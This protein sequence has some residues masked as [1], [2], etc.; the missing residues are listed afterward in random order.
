MPVDYELNPGLDNRV[1]DI[2]R[3]EEFQ[4]FEQHDI[5]VKTCLKVTMDETDEIVPC[6]GDKVELKKVHP[7]FRLFAEANFVLVVDA[8]TWANSSQTYM[9]GLI[10]SALMRV[11]FKV[12]DSGKV[13]VSKRPFDVLEFRRT[14]TRY[15]LWNEGVT[16]FAEMVTAAANVA[17]EHIAQIVRS[18]LTPQPEDEES[19]TRPVRRPGRPVRARSSSGTEE[20]QVSSGEET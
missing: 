8:A 17:G 6:K 15:G 5:A 12:N 13:T 14:I 2:L 11:Q 16:Q 9:D 10:H 20:S 1:S 3:F 4:P 7:A 18:T 19:P